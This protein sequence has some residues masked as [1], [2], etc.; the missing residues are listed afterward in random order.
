MTEPMG[1]RIMTPMTTANPTAM[2]ELIT[3]YSPARS[4]MAAR[5]SRR[6]RAPWVSIRPKIPE[7]L[8]VS[9][10][11][12]P[13]SG[14]SDTTSTGTCAVPMV[15]S[16]IWASVRCL[17]RTRITNET[18]T[19]AR[20]PP[21][22]TAA[23]N[24]APCVPIWVA[25]IMALTFRPAG[26]RASRR[27]PRRAA[28]P[29]GPAE[30]GGDDG[31]RTDPPVPRTASLSLRKRCAG[32]STP[33]SASSSRILGRRPVGTRRPKPSCMSTRWKMS[34]RR[35]VSPSMP[36]ISVMECTTRG[37]AGVRCSCT[38]QPIAMTI[39]S[40]MARCGQLDAS[41]HDHG[42]QTTQQLARRIGV[43]RRHGPGVARVHGLE[44][45]ERLG[46]TTLS[47]D[48]AVGPHTK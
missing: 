16:R 9:A 10:E 6:S 46:A 33:L 24:A 25:G 31:R 21:I 28:R 3:R 23:T 15:S 22:R 39:C 13:C 36:W 12:S 45:V 35:T 4:G 32:T 48:D 41:H 37:P 17:V 34:C 44:H 14:D 2:A 18:T 1:D 40:R 38:R 5:S 19:I 42:L 27:S 26:G 29:P 8:T 47:D 7:I 43:H 20:P 30:P 11:S